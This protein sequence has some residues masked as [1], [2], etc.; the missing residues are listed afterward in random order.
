MSYLSTE[1]QGL[2]RVRPEDAVESHLSRLELG[3]S[4]SLGKAE[5]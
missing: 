5:E 3:H 2:A 4:V 1:N